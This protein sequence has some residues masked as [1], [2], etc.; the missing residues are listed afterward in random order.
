MNELTLATIPQVVRQECDLWH[1][2]FV[3][4]GEDG[5]TGITAGLR[6]VAKQFGVS[7]ATARRKYSA[8]QHANG[9]RLALVNRSKARRSSAPGVEG[10]EEF[11]EWYVALAERNQRASKPA[12]REFCRRWL[13]GEEIPGLDNSLPRHRLPEGCSYEN[14]Q[15][16]MKDRLALTA[17]R[18]GLGFALGKHGPQVFSTRV[19]MRV[20]QCYMFDDL[21]HDNFVVYKGQIVRVLEFDALDVASG[22]KVSW[23]T[24]PRIQRADGTQEGLPERFMRMLLASVLFNEGYS[25]EGC[26]LLAEHGTAAIRERLEA[27]LH[28]RTGG[29][30]RVQR[31]G[32]TGEQQAFLGLGKGQGKGN[33]RFKAS[34]E[35]L[36]SLMHNELAALPG[37]TGLGR[38]ERPEYTHGILC[39]TEDLVKAVQVLAKER[40]AVAEWIRLPMLQYHAHFLPLLAAIYERINRRTWHRLEGWT[41]CGHVAIEYRLSP[42]SGEWFGQEGL[43]AMPR[44]NQSLVTSS[45]TLIRE[46]QLSPWEVWRAG[47]PGLAR[48]PAW[49]V[50]EILGDDFAAERKCEDGYFEFQDQELSPEVL[51]YEGR[52]S[53]EQGAGS[54]EELK[55]DTYK[56]FVNPF[57]LDQLFVHDARGRY[58]GAARRVKRVMRGDVEGLN[59]EFGRR[60]QRLAELL[61]PLRARHATVTREAAERAAHNADVLA[62]A[63]EGP[64]LTAGERRSGREA[65]EALLAPASQA[66]EAVDGKGDFEGVGVDDFLGKI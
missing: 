60:N 30:I 17:M 10:R 7:F 48:I 66:V 35:S 25:P 53:M 18:R 39:E 19:G 21:W 2:A 44:E 41:E 33:P 61:Q 56:V 64:R 36:R 59:A 50:A 29:V 38:D 3:G 37:Q 13:S 42:E 23:G 11:R 1:R 58:L 6:V 65:A 54:E 20:G 43:L 47:R 14:L 9:D 62:G 27:L 32:M 8:W 24:K 28:D 34:L 4:L 5:A 40:P 15:R 45:P 16:L 63:M 31:S 12:H 55:A 51:R 26:T 57:D 46:R 49:V 52:I 22:C